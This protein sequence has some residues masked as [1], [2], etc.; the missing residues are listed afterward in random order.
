MP[1]NKKQSDSENCKLQ[2][3]H[4][5]Q[6]GDGCGHQAV[7]HDDH[8]DY[9]HDGHRHRIHGKHVDECKPKNASELDPPLIRGLY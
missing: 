9:I 3:P 4:R 8:V 7:K 2:T 6:H 1:K 5:H